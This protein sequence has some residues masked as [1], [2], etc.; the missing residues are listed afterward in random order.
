[1]GGTSRAATHALC[2]P[3]PPRPT[4]SLGVSLDPPEA[5][6]R[7]CACARPTQSTRR[8]SPVSPARHLRPLPVPRPP[9][10]YT[11]PRPPH[12]P[13]FPRSAHLHM[14]SVVCSGGGP[15]CGQEQA[16]SSRLLFPLRTLS[17]GAAIACPSRIFA[18]ASEMIRPGLCGV[19]VATGARG[20]GGGQ[21]QEEGAARTAAPRRKIPVSQ[22]HAR[23]AA[24]LPASGTTTASSEDP[25][26]LLAAAV[27]PP[28]GEEL[29]ERPTLAHEPLTRRLP[30]ASTCT[31][32]SL[33]EMLSRRRRREG[34]HRHPDRAASNGRG[35]SVWSVRGP[36]VKRRRVAMHV[37]RE[38]VFPPRPA[39]P[40]RPASTSPPPPNRGGGE[41]GKG[42]TTH[43]H[44]HPPRA[45]SPPPVPVARA[46]LCP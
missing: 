10:P 31:A 9:A 42:P 3:F 11:R 24:Y 37:Q 44:S 41:R 34:P 14:L 21:R 5:P 32:L 27:V 6:T 2:P 43:T 22:Q 36:R 20:A 46:P 4:P 16:V 7:P 40:R 19:V 26:L 17:P 28:A 23:D 18:R 15:W 38:R 1:V 25:R 33:S 8:P 35:A 12:A 13:P 30:L 39:R 29:R 45:P